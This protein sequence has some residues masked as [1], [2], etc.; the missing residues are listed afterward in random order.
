MEIERKVEVLIDAVRAMTAENMAMRM[1]MRVA[2]ALISA[3][4]NARL[5]SMTI[6]YDALAD[7]LK[8]AGSDAEFRQ[9]ALAEFESLTALM[10]SEE[11]DIL[12]DR[13]TEPPDGDGSERKTLS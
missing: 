11:L 1:A 10:L 13:P 4:R 2:L 3:P 12:R 5:S 6:A 9:I 7:E 8:E